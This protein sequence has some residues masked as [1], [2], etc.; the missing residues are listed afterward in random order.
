MKK[1][2]FSIRKSLKGNYNDIET[3]NVKREVL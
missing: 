3:K 2:K 1:K